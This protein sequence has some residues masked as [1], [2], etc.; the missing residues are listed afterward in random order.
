M[1]SITSNLYYSD[2][3]YLVGSLT[4]RLLRATL[5]GTAGTTSAGAAASPER[6]CRFAF[7]VVVAEALRLPVWE[8]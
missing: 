5:A 3:V 1:L 7:G 2:Y 8:V 6:F 4:A